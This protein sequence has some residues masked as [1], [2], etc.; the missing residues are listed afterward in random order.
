[1]T[2]RFLC[3]SPLIF[4]PHSQAKHIILQSCMQ[5]VH[6]EHP[7]NK[8]TDPSIYSN[9]DTSETLVDPKTVKKI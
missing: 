7:Q 8:C 5:A 3:K 4:L 6:W 1:M 2:E 9:E